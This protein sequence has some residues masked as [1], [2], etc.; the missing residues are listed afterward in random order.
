VASTVDGG[1]RGRWVAGAAERGGVC[2]VCQARD[3]DG[4]G[5]GNSEA[6]RALEGE[7]DGVDRGL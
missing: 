6:G 5:G 7:H 3:G 4:A 1:A 2:R